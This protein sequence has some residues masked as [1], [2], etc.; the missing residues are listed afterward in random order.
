MFNEA[1]LKNLKTGFKEVMNIVAKNNAQR[2]VV[3]EDCEDRMKSQI[4]QAA[5]QTGVDVEYAQTMKQLGKLC[6]IDVGAS[7]AVVKKF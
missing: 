4:I 1:E 2:I 6:G 5:E 7:C 3:A